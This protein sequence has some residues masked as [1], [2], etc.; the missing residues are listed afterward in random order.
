MAVPSQRSRRGDNVYSTAMCIAAVV[1]LVVQGNG[2]HRVLQQD[3]YNLMHQAAQNDKRRLYLY[4][5]TC[6]SISTTA[7]KRAIMLGK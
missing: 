3:L 7:S 5:N 2:E 6:A 4:W 1:T